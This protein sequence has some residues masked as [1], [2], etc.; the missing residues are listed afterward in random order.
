[1]CGERVE[2]RVGRGVAA[3]ARAAEQSGERGVEDERGQ[4]EFAGQFVQIPGRVRLGA[5][6]G[7]EPFRGERAD[8]AVVHDARGVHD[9]GQRML[10]RNLGEH[11]RQLVALG[12]VGGGD[13]HVRAEFGQPGRELGGSRGVGAAPAE[14][15]QMAD[16]V[17]DDEVLGQPRPERPGAAGDQHR[18]LCVP[19]GRMPGR[20]LRGG[21]GAHQARDEQGASVPRRA[22][23]VSPVAR[24]E[25]A[26]RR[27]ASGSSAASPA[28]SRSTMRP[29]ISACAERTRPQ[30]AACRGSASSP[31]SVDTAA[32]VTTTSVAGPSCV[33]RRC[34]GGV[35]ASRVEQ[36]RHR[37]P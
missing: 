23:C 3:L 21:L 19:F 22:S 24:A 33:R 29:G 16:S 32:R 18:A 1:V 14:Q 28:T 13:P 11:G 34:L 17:F 27:Q 6:H 8:Q 35:R 20:R 36:I 10:R 31:G 9:G 4:V 26:A 15:Q 30:I 25:A 2:V 12:R 7:I 5:Q 37:R